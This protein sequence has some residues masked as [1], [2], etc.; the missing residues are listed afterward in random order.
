MV[1]KA[2]MRPPKMP[3]S[4]QGIALSGCGE[5]ERPHVQAEVAM[6]QRS[7][8]PVLLTVPWTVI[9]SPTPTAPWKAFSLSAGLEVRK[10]LG[11]VLS[12]FRCDVFRCGVALCCVTSILLP[13][14]H[15][16]QFDGPR[17]EA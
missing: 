13:T 15:G 16:Y 12:L 5:C 7:R 10:G 6:T 3:P 9:A 2:A 4:I 8:T 1:I 14:K 17:T 11:M